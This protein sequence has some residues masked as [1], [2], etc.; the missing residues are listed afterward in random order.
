MS[1]FSKVKE[2][3]GEARNNIGYLKADY[4]ERKKEGR[5]KELAKLKEETRV[6]NIRSENQRS[7]NR[8]EALK[9]NRSS[10][11]KK[12]GAAGDKVRR[13]GFSF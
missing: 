2:K 9:Q 11:I 12:M 5:E 6:Y 4:Q 10:T 3:Y 8:Y 1:F 7:K 13:G